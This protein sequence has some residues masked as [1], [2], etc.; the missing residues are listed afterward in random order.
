[1][2]RKRA[3]LE[4]LYALLQDNQYAQVLELGPS[5]LGTEPDKLAVVEAMLD[6][7]ENLLHDGEVPDQK[8]MK[9]L[10]KALRVEK[11]RLVDA[12]A[13]SDVYARFLDPP[14]E[15]NES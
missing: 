9:E 3:G 10:E 6:A 2:K 14:Q 15:G 4:E 5:L 8:S 11:K 12:G 7:V 1:M 13:K